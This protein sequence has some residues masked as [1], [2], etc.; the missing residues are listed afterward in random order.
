MLRNPQGPQGPQGQGYYQPVTPPVEAPVIAMAAKGFQ[1]IE[2]HV[3]ERLENETEET[4]NN[5]IK[6]DL[7]VMCQER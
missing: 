6:A 1:T 2:R 5:R 4:L 3:D 7:V